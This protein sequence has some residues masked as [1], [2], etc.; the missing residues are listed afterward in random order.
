MAGN[1][2]LVDL[3]V[4]K[5]G[6]TV[7][8]AIITGLLAYLTGVRLEARKNK[9]A[10]KQ[11]S[12]DMDVDSSLVEVKEELRGQVQVRYGEE[13]VRDLTTVTFRIVNTG[14]APV[15]NEFVRFAFPSDAKVLEAALDP[16]PEPELD[17][18][19][20]TDS[21]TPP[22]SRRFRIGHLEP[23]QSVQFRFISDGGDWANWT[24]IHPKNEEGGVAFERGDVSR[25]KED[26]EHV[27]PFV[28]QAVLLTLSQLVLS[29]SSGFYIDGVIQL[30]RIVATLLIGG[31]MLP[32]L[33]PVAR[34]VERVAVRYATG[35]GESMNSLGRVEPG[36][37]VLQ[38]GSVSGGVVVHP[39][40]TDS[41]EAREHGEE[42]NGQRVERGS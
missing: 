39:G 25:V 35:G 2:Q 28:V 11:L 26:Q 42:D 10:L 32:H 9:K 21:D 29:L 16:V 18:S 17:V 33:L 8:A 30:V 5:Y 24:D 34:I 23:G 1:T 36:G 13:T 27:R 19:E 20:V 31:L 22:G 3:L 38:A 37:T 4:T 40:R 6:P 15:F 41:E 12:W 7:F 14:G